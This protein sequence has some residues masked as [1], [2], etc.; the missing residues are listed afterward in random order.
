MKVESNVEVD[1]RERAAVQNE[2]GMRGWDVSRSVN[3]DYCKQGTNEGG[4][5]LCA[6]WEVLL[7]RSLRYALSSNNAERTKGRTDA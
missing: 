5:C 1:V 6:V 2:V 7:L 4:T 3:G